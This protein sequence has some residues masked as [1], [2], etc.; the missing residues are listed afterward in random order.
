MAAATRV[1][2]SLKRSLPRLEREAA[3]L[4]RSRCALALNAARACGEAYGLIVGTSRQP[5]VVDLLWDDKQLLGPRQ[6]LGPFLRQG[7]LTQD[8]AKAAWLRGYK[9]GAKK[10]EFRQGSR[11]RT[12]KTST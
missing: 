1:N 2:A 11:P 4:Q 3:K 10:P 6:Y 12:G 9:A 7:L 8:E 5:L